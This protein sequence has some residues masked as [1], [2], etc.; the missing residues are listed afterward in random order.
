[1]TQAACPRC[2]YDLS[3]HM[4]SWERACPLEGRCSECGLGFAWREVLVDRERRNPRHVEHCPRA[5]IPSAVLRTSLWCVLPWVFGRRVRMAH[6]PRV[7][8]M[9]LWL[10]I[11]LFALHV[12]ASLATALGIGLIE[13]RDAAHFNRTR[14]RNVQILTQFRATLLAQDPSEVTNLADQLA[15][16]DEGIAFSSRPLPE[17]MMK[18]NDL[19]RAF[20]APVLFVRDDSDAISKY[21]V[22][23]TAF[24]PRLKSGWQVSLLRFWRHRAFLAGLTLSIAYPML[25]LALPAT[26][27]RLR[28]RSGHLWRATIFG[29]AWLAIPALV[30][31]GEAIALVS[32]ELTTPMSR[33]GTPPSPLGDTWTR[34]WALWTWVILIW[35]SAWWLSVL[36]RG[37]RFPRPLFHWSLITLAAVLLAVIA[38]LMVTNLDGFG[39]FLDL[40]RWLVPNHRSSLQRL[41]DHGV[42]YVR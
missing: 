25:L 15:D 26:R 37:L 19:V 13:R 27:R 4:A 39:H 1:M 41:A 3:G 14:A 24:K 34:D 32:V 35:T 38:L 40:D 18:P 7:R 36:W 29:M 8:R 6:E 31:L 23:R 28:I 12:P 16:L 22:G 30:R 5:K 9:V 33:V 42:D 20:F 11:F 21:R 10:A 17:A 2:G